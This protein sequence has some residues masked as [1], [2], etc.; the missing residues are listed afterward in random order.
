MEFGSLPITLEP[1]D[2]HL[3]HV[4]AQT[5]TRRQREDDSAIPLAIDLFRLV[6]IKPSFASPNVRAKLLYEFDLSGFYFAI[7]RKSRVRSNVKHSDLQNV[8]RD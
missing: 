2:R 1:L 4:V 5:K 6:F 3:H 8:V 7:A